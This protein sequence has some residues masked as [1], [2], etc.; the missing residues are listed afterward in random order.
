MTHLPASPSVG[1]GAGRQGFES[2]Y[3]DMAGTCPVPPL[4]DRRGQ[5]AQ[6]KMRLPCREAPSCLPRPNGVG[7]RLQMH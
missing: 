1:T 2:D 4:R 3:T 5:G 7:G 6:Y